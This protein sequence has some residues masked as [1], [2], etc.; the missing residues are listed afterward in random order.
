MACSV[1]ELSAFSVKVGAARLQIRELKQSCSERTNLSYCVQ[2]RALVSAC[3]RHCI[4][5]VSPEFEQKVQ[6]ILLLC[7]LYCFQ[8]YSS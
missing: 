4:Q 6:C 3:E 1:L 8:L 7:F 2:C 5:T